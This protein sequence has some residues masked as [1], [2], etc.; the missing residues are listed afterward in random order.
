MRAYQEAVNDT[1]AQDKFAPGKRIS[2]SADNWSR[3]IA[4][5]N[6]TALDLM[7]GLGIATGPKLD[8]RPWRWALALGA[9]IL[10]VNAA[11]LNIDWWRMKSETNSLR[12]SM[13]QI[14]KSAYPKESVIID[15]VAQMQQKI[16]IAKHNSGLP[17][18]DDFT[19]IIAAFGEAWA[20]TVAKAGKATEIAALEYH[21]HS[22]YVRLK[23][24]GESPTQQMKAALAR[25]QLALELAPEQSGA[26]VW[27]IRSGK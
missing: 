11:A 8:W 20:S 21:E 5:A 6:G 14:Y 26:V 2:V 13:I 27:Q 12:E 10:I 7:A 17:A 1:G 24:G 15:P 9:A 19:A 3:W 22:L 23:R 16:A 25:Y 18:P 4:G